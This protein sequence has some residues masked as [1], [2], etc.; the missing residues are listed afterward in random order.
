MYYKTITRRRRTI[1]SKRNIHG[2]RV[3]IP[4]KGKSKGR[5][6]VKPVRI[7]IL[8][9]SIQY[10]LLFSFDSTVTIPI[11]FWGVQYVLTTPF[12]RAQIR[13]YASRAAH[14]NYPTA[15]VRYLPQTPFD[16]TFTTPRKLEIYRKNI[17][18]GDVKHNAR[19]AFSLGIS[20]VLNEPLPRPRKPQ[21]RG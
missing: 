8:E 15:T 12:S 11:R 1:A 2:V 14:L 10:P 19:L 5:R 6:W 3:F 17:R 13:T 16:L 9:P 4:L 18:P 21:K 20:Q 7:N